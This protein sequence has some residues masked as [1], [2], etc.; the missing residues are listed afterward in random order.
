MSLSGEEFITKENSE[1]ILDWAKDVIRRI[2][3][4]Y[5]VLDGDFLYVSGVPLSG[6]DDF[7]FSGADESTLLE[8]LLE[9]Y[10]FD[11]VHLT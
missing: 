10:G 2:P 7:A 6:D 8:Y 3:G 11:K 9:K 5:L 4:T 1:E